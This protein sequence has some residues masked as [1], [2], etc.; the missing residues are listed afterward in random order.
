[1]TPGQMRRRSGLIA[2]YT[3]R[4]AH[5]LEQAGGEA[6]PRLAEAHQLAVALQARLLTALEG[7][8]EA[9]QSMPREDG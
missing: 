8:L 1:M 9:S 2:E 3:E 4:L 7:A 5:V 6:D